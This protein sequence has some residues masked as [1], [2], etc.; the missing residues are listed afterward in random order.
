MWLSFHP[1]ESLRRA[2]PQSRATIPEAGQFPS[3]SVSVVPSQHRHPAEWE[4]ALATAPLQILHQRNINTEVLRG[5][6]R[7]SPR[8][9]EL[10]AQHLPKFL[11]GLGRDFAG[12]KGSRIYNALTNGELTYRS[13]C[14]QKPGGNVQAV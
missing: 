12:T 13:Y 1:A 10:I 14:L 8:S 9:L 4:N 11:H 6:D 7:N 3:S 2:L 5:M